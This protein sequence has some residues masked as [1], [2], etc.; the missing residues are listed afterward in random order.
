MLAMIFS[1]APPVLSQFGGRSEDA[2]LPRGPC[3]SISIAIYH[4]YSNPTQFFISIGETGP[5]P[6]K[7]ERREGLSLMPRHP[8]RG[9]GASTI[10]QSNPGNDMEEM[11]CSTP[12]R[13]PSL[14]GG[15]SEHAA[16]SVVVVPR[17]PQFAAQSEH[18]V[19]LSGTCSS[20]S[21][22][23]YLLYS[24]PTRFIISIGETGRIWAKGRRG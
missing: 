6:G 4:F 17:S 11:V 8:R 1:I 3:S 9:D 21:I 2:V 19:L 10:R 5:I 13:I 16:L 20:I 15:R 14:F 22:A 7:V 23:I 18:A 12:P 24:N